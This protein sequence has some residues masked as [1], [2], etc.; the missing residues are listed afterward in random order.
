MSTFDTETLPHD[1]YMALHA[2]DE[3]QVGTPAYLGLA[4]FWAYEY[5]Y[6]L[7]DVS[8]AARRRIHAAML[9]AGLPL[10]RRSAAHAR[11]IE[12]N[13]TATDRRRLTAAYYYGEP[14]ATA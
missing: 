1:A 8:Y 13:L 7:R 5:R 4:Y 6:P 2:H 11:I 10:D 12:E 3:T 14:G 9:D